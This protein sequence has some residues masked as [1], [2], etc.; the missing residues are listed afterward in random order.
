VTNLERT[1][2]HRAQSAVQGQVA[3]DHIYKQ[4]TEEEASKEEHTHTTPLTRFRWHEPG[5]HG[6]GGHDSPPV[7]DF[8]APSSLEGSL[9]EA[10]FVTAESMSASSLDLR[11]VGGTVVRGSLV[12]GGVRNLSLVQCFG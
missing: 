7:D 6:E 4:R 11:R 12:G 10:R 2:W 9:L 3:R 5:G 8:S 1:P